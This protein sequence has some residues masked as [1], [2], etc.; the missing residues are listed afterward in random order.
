MK[1][2]KPNC[3]VQFTAEDLDFMVS[4]LGPNKLTPEILAQLLADPDS[5]DL[6]LEDECLYRALLERN[7]CI[8]VSSHFYFYVLVRRGLKGAG[9]DDRTVADYVAEVLS[10]FSHAER[11]RCTVSGQSMSLDYF[12]EMMAAL[13]HVDE[14]TRFIIRAHIGNQSLFLSGVFPERIRHRAEQKG[15]PDLSYY[16]DM[17]RMNFRAA[18]DHALARR[19]DLSDIFQILSDHFRAARLA[20]NDLAERLFMLDSPPVPPGLLLGR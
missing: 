20:L 14:R 17:G 3:R 15:F 6:I 16:E 9:I 1:V 8:Q 19:Y 5:R 18:R 4:V 10:E 13:E 11:A 2:I 7:C 12:F